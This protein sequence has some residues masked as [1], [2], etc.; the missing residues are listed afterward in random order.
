MTKRL[1]TRIT[2]IVAA[3]SVFGTSVLLC[4]CFDIHG[5]KERK[6]IIEYMDAIPVTCT[7]Y[8]L[9][10]PDDS[11]YSYCVG[12][13]KL[14]NPNAIIVDG[15]E[16]KIDIV[17]SKDK[18]YS[19]TI[20]DQTININEAFMAEKSPEYVTISEIWY[21]YND[22]MENYK[23]NMPPFRICVFDN[24]VFISTK[25]KRGGG[26]WHFRYGGAIPACLFKYNIESESVLYAGYLMRDGMEGIFQ[27]EKT[28]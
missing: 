13:G 12:N 22:N 23:D 11:K 2:A 20:D 19:L 16:K 4:G 15:I 5:E 26:A 24:N 3:A 27:I 6:Y 8:K 9:A 28:E 17:R 21:R 18:D 25:F 14:D 1:S 10:L 7:E